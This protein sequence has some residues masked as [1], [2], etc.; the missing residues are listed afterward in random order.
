MTSS[1]PQTLPQEAEVPVEEKKNDTSL[2][3]LENTTHGGFQGKMK[4]YLKRDAQYVPKI[5]INS[6][7]GDDGEDLK[8]VSTNV[9]TRPIVLYNVKVSY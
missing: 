1:A 7:K 4:Y 8:D 3:E 5:N 9:Y 6:E 2:N